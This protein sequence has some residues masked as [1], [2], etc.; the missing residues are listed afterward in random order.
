MTLSEIKNWVSSMRAIA[1]TQELPPASERL[2]IYKKLA[3]YECWDA[4]F[5]LINTAT[6]QEQATLDDFFF[7]AQVEYDDFN[8]VSSFTKT[9]RSAI[10]SLDLS[11]EE[12]HTHLIIKI[13]GQAR[14]REE[15]KV[16]GNLWT[17][18]SKKS[19]RAS[20]LERLCLIYEKKIFQEDKLTQSYQSLFDLEPENSKALKYFKMVSIQDRK[21]EKVVSILETLINTSTHREDVFRSALELAAVQ[22]YQL[23]EPRAAIST[24][25]KHCSG[26][27]LDSSTIHLEAY[28][29]LGDGAG[30]L[31]VLNSLLNKNV[32]KGVE[33]VILF[34]MGEIHEALD[35]MDEAVSCYQKSLHIAP[36]LLEASERTIKILLRR[37]KWVDALRA[38][39][40]FGIGLS[41][42]NLRK[43]LETKIADL[44]KALEVESA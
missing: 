37:H 38:L 7:R 30:C 5:Q 27:H 35:R 32:E 17:A 9:C 36:Q 28:Q 15:A 1:L 39:S 34:R 40:Q 29:R 11:F 31:R 12:T 8:D 44:K 6:K 19:C 14:W 10:E 18:F 24:I 22:L 16:L 2:D 20:C 33:A 4:M 25:E 21:W 42:T 23:D 26:G 3:D 41:D 43:Q 13:L